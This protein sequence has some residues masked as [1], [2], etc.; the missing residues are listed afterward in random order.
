MISKRETMD[1]TGSVYLISSDGQTI[2]LPIPTKSRRDP[3]NWGKWK[4]IWAFTS[5]MFSAI[6]SMAAV[7][8]ASL[9]LQPLSVEYSDEVS[10]L[11]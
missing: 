8:I 1:L 2:K 4:R 3:L 11:L 9:L 6:T 5:L 7:Q 10:L